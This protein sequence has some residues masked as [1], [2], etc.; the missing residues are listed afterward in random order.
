MQ[1]DLQEILKNRLGFI[2]KMIIKPQI[3]YGAALSGATSAYRM[4]FWTSYESTRHDSEV[5]DG[6]H[7]ARFRYSE[8]KAITECTKLML[9]RQRR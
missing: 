5:N 4:P 8:I 6:Y 1:K 9:K 3:T 7:K 2:F